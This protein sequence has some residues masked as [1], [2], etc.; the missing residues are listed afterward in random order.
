M[1]SEPATYPGYRFPAEIISHAVWLYHVFSLSLRDVELILAERGIIVTRERIR[2][3]CCKFGS[4]FAAKLRRRRPKPG[5]TWH[6]DEVFLRINGVLHYL[7]R[8]VDQHGLVLDILVQDRRNG[9]AAKRFF[10]R[11][12][13]GLRYKPR[14]LVTDGLRSYGVAQRELLPEVP[15]RSSRY[16]NNRAENSHRPTRRRERQMQ[17]FKSPEQTQRFLSA[18]SMIYG[19]FRPRRHL[20]TAGEYRRARTKAFRSWQQETCVQTAS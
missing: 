12:L 2:N 10:K 9:S 5:D 7:W 8:A 20:M 15:H 16:L 14:R 18:H 19:Q 13:A 17:R 1:T 4:E 3:W 11:L 6:L